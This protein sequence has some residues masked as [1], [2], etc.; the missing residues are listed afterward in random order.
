MGWLI[1]ACMV[2][3]AVLCAVT[4]TRPELSGFGAFSFAVTRQRAGKLTW[5]SGWSPAEAGLI[6]RSPPALSKLC[7]PGGRAA[8]MP[9]EYG[10]DFL[11]IGPVGVA[12]WG[13]AAASRAGAL[14]FEAALAIVT[15]VGEA[16]KLYR[17][18]AER[19]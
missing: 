7:K 5:R 10:P 4:L 19:S 3:A 17:K 9:K 2:A 16:M 12:V 18:F 15:G 8:V 11:N 14:S 1:P 6:G 13:V